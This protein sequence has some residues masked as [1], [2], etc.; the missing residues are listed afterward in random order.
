MVLL[1]TPPGELGSTA[2]GF[3]LPGVDDR[4]HAFDDYRDASILVVMFICN[5][6]P[7]VQSVEGRLI[8]LATEM[9]SQGVRFVA[10]N[11]N[12]PTNYPDDSFANMKS[13]A[14]EKGYPFDYLCDETQ[15]V[16]RAYGAVCTPDFFVYD[17]ERK[18]RYRGRL[19]DS[20]RNP[21][22]VKSQEMKAAITTLLEGG[23][24]EGHQHSA[25]GCS[26]KWRGEPPG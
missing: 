25:M 4:T 22:A 17:Q 7:Y 2:P 13:R 14:A 11:S 3:S 10:I 24:L 8:A 19:D 16:A 15:D 5:H 21:A 12:D 9:K 26:I 20:P 18:L 6:C 23:T 1:H